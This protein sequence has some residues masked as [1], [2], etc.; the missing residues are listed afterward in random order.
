MLQPLCA[1]R[2]LLDMP[3]AWAL[4]RPRIS[5]HSYR[6]QLPAD[7]QPC[8]VQVLRCDVCRDWSVSWRSCPH[9]AAPCRLSRTA[10]GDNDA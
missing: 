5:G 6:E 2:S 10:G 7:G 4:G 1:L 8:C 9:C 3:V